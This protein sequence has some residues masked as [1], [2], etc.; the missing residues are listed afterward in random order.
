MCPSEFWGRSKKIENKVMNK[1]TLKS[2]LENMNMKGL[3]EYVKKNNLKAKDTD[4]EE[5]ISEI[6]QEV[7]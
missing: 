7:N 3:R 6:L 2:K 4:K 5:L 1:D